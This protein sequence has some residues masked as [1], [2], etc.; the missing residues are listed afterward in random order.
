MAEVDSKRAQRISRRKKLHA[1]KD[2]RN[3]IRKVHKKKT[4]K[5][6]LSNEETTHTAIPQINA[7][8]TKIIRKYTDYISKVARVI[9][10]EQGTEISQEH[11]AED[12]Q[13]M[14]N[15]QIKLIQVKIVLLLHFAKESRR[16]F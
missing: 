8:Q 14:V 3:H 9:A 13:D 1:R 2:R 11:L 12:I 7:K 15:F 6:I 10:R 16:D 5:K 4:E